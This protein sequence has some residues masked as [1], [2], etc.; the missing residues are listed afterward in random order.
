MCFVLCCFVWWVR[1][2]E[3]NVFLWQ[4]GWDL[5]R[6]YSGMIHGLVRV[7][8]MVTS[9]TWVKLHYS[10]LQF[11]NYTVYGLVWLSFFWE[12]YTVCGEL[13][14]SLDMID[15][16]GGKII[17][18]KRAPCAAPTE[19]TYVVDSWNNYKFVVVRI[20]K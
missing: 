10:T 1:E 16:W 18:W 5:G 8:I 13:E 4:W 7:D 12:E 19:Q 9:I 3:R 11:Y 15:D 20:W 14:Y 17:M 6:E 2:R